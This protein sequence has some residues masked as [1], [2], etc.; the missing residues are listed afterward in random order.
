ME[1][2]STKVATTTIFAI[3][4]LATYIVDCLNKHLCVR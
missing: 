4:F 3:V 1:G 2:L